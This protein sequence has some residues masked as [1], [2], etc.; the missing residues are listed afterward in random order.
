MIIDY[1]GARPRI[2]RE[3]FVA[4]N[5]TVIGQVTLG[6]QSSVWYGSV[7]RGDV[8]TIAIGARTNLQDLS[9][10]HVTTNKHDTKI[11]SDVVVGHRVVLHGCTVGDRCLIGMGSV[12]MDGADV[13]DF[14]LVGAGALVTPGTKIPAG[15]MALGSPAKVVRQL[16]DNERRAIEENAAHYVD[17]AREHLRA[18]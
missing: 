6:D 5:A 2:G 7:V 14:A 3:V 13:G 8:G 11:G 17:L 18:G 16:T 9:V 15:A 12:V 10:V 1:K 4:P